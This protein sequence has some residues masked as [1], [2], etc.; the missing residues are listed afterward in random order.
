MGVPESLGMTRREYA[1][2][3]RVSIRSAVERRAKEIELHD[4]G[5]SNRMIADLLGV[6][7]G[8]VRN[9]LGAQ[10]YAQDNDGQEADD[11]DTRPR[12]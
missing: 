3:M 4:A 1:D 6:S 5:E 10:D 7:E 9:D 8:T 11:S 12:D 2:S